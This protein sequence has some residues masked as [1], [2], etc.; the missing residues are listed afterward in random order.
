MSQPKMAMTAL[1]GQFGVAS[2]PLGA[3]ADIKRKQKHPPPFSIRFTEAERA[4]L[5]RDAGALSLAAYIRL[6]LFAGEEP[7]PT[8]RK[9]T[10]RTYQ[11]SAELA[12]LGHMLGGLGQSRMASNLNQIAR[13]ANTGTLS[14]TPELERELSEACA[15]IQTMRHD[16]TMALGLKSKSGP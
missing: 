3:S 12:V 2:G 1:S 16:L 11:P 10:R 7:P 8:P 9:P 5:D 15:A 4:R 14:V 6:K 13:A